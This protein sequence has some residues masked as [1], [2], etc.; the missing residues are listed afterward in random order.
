MGGGREVE[1]EVRVMYHI[2][3][4]AALSYVKGS[5]LDKGVLVLIQGIMYLD[6]VTSS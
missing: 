5:W 1:V 2:A 4:A 3:E 6:I